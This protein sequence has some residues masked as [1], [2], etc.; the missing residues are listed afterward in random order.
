MHG[1]FFALYKGG[2][3]MSRAFEPKG[4]MAL[5]ACVVIITLFLAGCGRDS[6]SGGESTSVINSENKINCVTKV[7]NP[8][9][10][11]SDKRGPAHCHNIHSPGHQKH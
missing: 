11:F 8:P 3:A 2:G 4:K 7:R 6:S 5:A 9:S 10:I 1:R